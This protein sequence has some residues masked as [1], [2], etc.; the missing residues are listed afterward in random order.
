M[1]GVPGFRWAGEVTWPR[2]VEAFRLHFAA[3]LERLHHMLRQHIL[4]PQNPFKTR[5]TPADTPRN[6]WVQAWVQLVPL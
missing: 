2:L 6:T 5:I 3:R 1:K 4:P